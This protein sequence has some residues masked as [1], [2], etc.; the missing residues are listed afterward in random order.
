MG[1]AFKALAVLSNGEQ[2]SQCMAGGTR[3]RKTAFSIRAAAHG[4]GTSGSPCVS[5]RRW[6]RWANLVRTAEKEDPVLGRLGACLH[7][8]QE[9]NLCFGQPWGGS[10]SPLL[11]TAMKADGDLRL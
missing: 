3:S 1:S 5:R 11:A 10:P 4:F 6:C 2:G 9:P 7:P 8:G